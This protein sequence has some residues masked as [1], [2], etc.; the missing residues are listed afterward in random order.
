[1]TASEFNDV[2]KCMYIVNVPETLTQIGY[3]ERM[4]WRMMIGRET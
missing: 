1:M 3:L 4:S 2:C